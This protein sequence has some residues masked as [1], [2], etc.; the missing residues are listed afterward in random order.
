MTVERVLYYACLLLSAIMALVNINALKKRRLSLF[1]P[2]LWLVLFQ[3]LTLVFIF[4]KMQTGI[5]YN[6]YR[7][8][9]TCFYAYIFYHIPFNTIRIRKAILWMLSVYLV[10]TILIYSFLQ[11]VSI[12]NRFV[13]F[14]GGFIITCWAIFFLY[15]YF[16]VDSVEEEKKWQPMIWITFGLVLYYPIV[17]IAFGFYLYIG[18][19]DVHLYNVKLYNIIP[20][21]MSIFMYGFFAYAFYLCRQKKLDLS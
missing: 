14:A 2:Y 10:V 16:H 19:Y 4:P 17:N 11:G 13:S 7:P 8:I 3:E 9:S 12:Y 20:R 18:K 1:I 6:F 15:R 21:V 5:V